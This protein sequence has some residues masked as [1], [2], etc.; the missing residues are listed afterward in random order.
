MAN[1]IDLTGQ[2]FGKLVA[3]KHIGYNNKHLTLWL[4]Q[5][6]CGNTTKVTTSDLRS[7]HSKSCGC[8][9]YGGG[10]RRL[11]HVWHTVKRRCEDE[12]DKS[13]QYYGA[14]GVKLCNEWHDYNIFREWAL[15]HGYNENASQWECT[16]DR[17]NPYGNYEPQNC[18]WIPMSEQNKNKRIHYKKEMEEK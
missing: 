4:C 16:L 11:Y 8:R 17:I 10:N 5:C 6:D 18:R 3:I 9:K 2:R 12:N 7:G 1:Y 13:Y 14:K 15:S